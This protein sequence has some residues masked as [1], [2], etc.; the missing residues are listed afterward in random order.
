MTAK[1]RRAGIF[2]LEDLQGLS[3][4]EVK[5]AVAELK[6]NAVQLRRLCAAVTKP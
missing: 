1:L 5:E 6:L 2:G 3:P 4:D